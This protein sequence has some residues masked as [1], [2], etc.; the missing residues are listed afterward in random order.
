MHLSIR[1]SRVWLLNVE[2]FPH[3]HHQVKVH[4]NSNFIKFWFFPSKGF[5][6]APN[7]R[8]DWS[9]PPG[10]PVI[11]RSCQCGKPV[12]VSP[13]D[14][15][16]WGLT[17][18]KLICDGGQMKLEWNHCVMIFQPQIRGAIWSFLRQK[19]KGVRVSCAK[20]W[21]GQRHRCGEKAN[22]AL[23]RGSGEGGGYL[24][25]LWSFGR[26]HT[27]GGVHWSSTIQVGPG[28]F[29]LKMF[30]DEMWGVLLRERQQHYGKHV[31]R[32]NI[33]STRKSLSF[34]LFAKSLHSSPFVPLCANRSHVQLQ[35]TPHRPTLSGSPTWLLNR[36]GKLRCSHHRMDSY[37]WGLQLG[38]T[39]RTSPFLAQRPLLAATL[40]QPEWTISQ[41]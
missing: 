24:E 21:V 14:Q 30:E 25:E 28:W 5:K 9:S 17:K 31:L 37:L 33:M 32:W 8:G 12:L 23:S 13:W 22:E 7:L 26:L 10:A 38:T 2:R 29:F 1:N 35:Q 39:S 4:Q 36:N 34:W 18:P 15:Y 40:I 20:G 27:G 3:Q 19:S 11:A 16:P 41:W 6:P